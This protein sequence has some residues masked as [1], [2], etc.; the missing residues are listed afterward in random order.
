MKKQE[1]PGYSLI[2]YRLIA[3]WVLSEA[4][5]GGIIH[6]LKLPVSGLVVGS[7]AVICICLIAFYVPHKGAII[8]A[9]IIVAIFKMMLSPQAP[10]PAYVAVFF[11]GLAGELLFMPSKYYRIVCILLAVLALAESGIQRILIMTIVYGN[12]LWNAIN[13]FINGLTGQK[14]LTD[15]SYFIIAWYLMAHLIIGVLVGVWAGILPQQIAYL[16]SVQK[17]Y[18]IMT[19][20]GNGISFLPVQ[21]KTKTRKILF[22]TWAILVLLYLQ[23]LLGIGRPL[24]P[25]SMA[26]RI[27]IRSAIIVL[28]WFF[29]VAPLLKQ[30]LKKWLEKKKTRSQRDIQQ[31]LELLP[32]TQQLVSKSWQLAREKKGWRRVKLCCKIIL[33]NTFHSKD[34][35]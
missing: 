20:P 3:L 14:E 18:T 1:V 8:K 4:M 25:S 13:S 6:A 32:A 29:I 30:A 24:L 31:V 2:Y 10:P 9:T 34:D 28:T 11:Q 27:L 21:R 33:A 35:A 23:S 26:I 22:I 7:A 17:Q 12:D 5:V 16:E 19:G 15:Y